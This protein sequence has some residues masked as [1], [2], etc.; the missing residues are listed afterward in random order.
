MDVDREVKKE[1]RVKFEQLVVKRVNEIKRKT[2]ILN[3]KNDQ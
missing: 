1:Q 3:K 2:R